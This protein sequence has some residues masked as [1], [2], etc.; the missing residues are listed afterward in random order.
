[1][2]TR[3]HTEK[4]GVVK[5]ATCS[6]HYPRWGQHARYHGWQTLLHLYRSNVDAT[7]HR[8]DSELASATDSA[9]P[10]LCIALTLQEQ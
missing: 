7:L 4:V 2:N 8:Y 5:A 1:M 10:L 3:S 9:P 6:C